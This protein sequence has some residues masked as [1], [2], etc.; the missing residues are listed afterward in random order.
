MCAFSRRDSLTSEPWFS[1]LHFGWRPRFECCRFWGRLRRR[2][3]SFELEPGV[4][5][6]GNDVSL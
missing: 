4:L 2:G 1:F 3:G 6:I 5:G